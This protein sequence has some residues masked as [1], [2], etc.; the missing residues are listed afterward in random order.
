MK[1]FT[2]TANLKLK[3]ENP[4][5]EALQDK[6]PGITDIIFKSREFSDYV[7]CVQSC[8]KL[9]DDFTKSTNA[10]PGNLQIGTEIN[11]KVSGEPTISKD[12][13]AT[14]IARLWVIDKSAGESSTILA[15]AQA[16]IFSDSSS[17]LIAN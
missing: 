7:E 2:Y 1:T 11:P 16:R 6:L 3:V 12:W 14:E 15:V 4:P 8:R 9:L 17:T 10:Q 5:L 13:S